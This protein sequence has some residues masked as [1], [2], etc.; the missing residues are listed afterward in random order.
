[1]ILK[2]AIE[3]Y[4]SGRHFPLSVLLTF[5]NYFCDKLLKRETL[6]ETRE[7]SECFGVFLNTVY[8]A[9]VQCVC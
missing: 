5:S 3:T 1:M 8:T 6:L 2:I 9:S 7:V 4:F